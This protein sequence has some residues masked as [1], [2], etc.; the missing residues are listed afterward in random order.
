MTKSMMDNCTWLSLVLALYFIH[1]RGTF[2]GRWSYKDTLRVS[3]TVIWL[4]GLSK[5]DTLIN[6][7][8][9]AISFF[10]TMFQT[11]RT[12][13]CI[14][15]EYDFVMWKHNTPNT[16]PVRMVDEALRHSRDQTK[17][18]YEINQQLGDQET[19]ESSEGD[20]RIIVSLVYTSGSQIVL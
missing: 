6:N 3:F 18:T 13:C 5:F 11:K 8:L 7:S 16:T 17:A 1:I 15:T 10:L 4:Y 12:S 14:Y 20:R 19:F 9:I 2:G